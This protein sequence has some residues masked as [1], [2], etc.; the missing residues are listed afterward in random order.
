MPILRNKEIQQMAIEEIDEKL[1]ELRAALMEERS[2]L[3][4]TGVTDKPAA[5]GNM[6]RTIAR[7]ETVRGT[8]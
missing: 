3:R 5:I 2:K 4:S 6:K 1:N 7:L 8:K